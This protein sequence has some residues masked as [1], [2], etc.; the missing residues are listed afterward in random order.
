MLAEV[1]N[2]VG[3]ALR[4]YDN[5]TLGSGLSNGGTNAY[6]DNVKLDLV[7]MDGVVALNGSGT[8]D[9]PS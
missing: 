3:T 8:A 5:I 2:N 7:P 9:A 1:V 4:Q 6:F